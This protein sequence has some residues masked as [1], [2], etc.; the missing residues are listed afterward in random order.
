MSEMLVPCP[1]MP[2]ATPDSA[3][4][5]SSTIDRIVHSARE[6]YQTCWQ[7]LQ[8]TLVNNMS[9]AEPE[10]V[11]A[12]KVF[13]TAW[14]DYTHKYGTAYQLTDGSAGV[15]FNDSTTMIMAPG[16]Q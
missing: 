11:T 5:F 12:P 9:I 14:I 13:I 6:A 3:N 8:D 16:R 4:K 2:Q 15:Y 10:S 7:T 1:E